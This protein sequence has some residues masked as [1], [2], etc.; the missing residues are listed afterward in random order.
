M[1]ASVYSHNPFVG[2]GRTIVSP[3]IA[4]PN[5][6]NSAIVVFLS[7]SNPLAPDNPL[8]RSSVGIGQNLPAQYITDNMGNVY[9]RVATINNNSLLINPLVFESIWVAIVNT[10]ITVP[11]QLTIGW[12]ATTAL[13]ADVVIV[14]PANPANQ[15][16]ID[17]SLSAAANITTDF[18][19]IGLNTLVNIADGLT[20]STN[21]LVLMGLSYVYTNL[22]LTT[23]PTPPLVSVVSPSALLD[24]IVSVG[25]F[26]GP[27][28]NNVSNY[29]GVGLVTLQ[30]TF[31]P[32]VA[33]MFINLTSQVQST[34][35]YIAIGIGVQEVPVGQ[36]QIPVVNSSIISSPF[37]AENVAQVPS[38]TTGMTVVKLPIGT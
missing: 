1:T 7:S 28:T 6:T 5:G 29:V 31:G 32:G 23:T 37:S 36:G 18:G 34:V 26:L 9:T 13:S 22:P 20:P 21:E 17:N 3:T 27:A 8:Y 10:P 30:Q 38:L 2:Y 33:N 19:N 15:I 25:Q 11:I 14:V 12:N 4:M 35:S 24:S 16:A